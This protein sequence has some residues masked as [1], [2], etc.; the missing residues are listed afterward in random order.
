MESCLSVLSSV[1]LGGI[2]C[3]SISPSGCVSL[4]SFHPDSRRF[5]RLAAGNQSSQFKVFCFFLSTAPQVF[6]RVRTS[7]SEILHQLPIRSLCFLDDWLILAS[8][9]EECFRAREVVLQLCP[10]LG[11]RIKGRKSSVTPIQI[12]SF[13]IVDEFSVFRAPP[14]AL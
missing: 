3:F 13:L 12:S 10:E 4:S 11:I 14:A 6:T 5:L 1:R 2:G 8:S 9:E 7:F